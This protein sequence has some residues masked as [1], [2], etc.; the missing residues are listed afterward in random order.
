MKRRTM[1][2]GLAGVAALGSAGAAIKRISGARAG[3]SGLSVTVRLDEPIGTIRPAIYS[4]FAEHIGG[5]IYDGIWV[6]AD[7]KVPNIGGI[8]KALVEHVKR[9]GKVVVRWPGGCFADRYHWRDGIGPV[10]SRP[11]RFGRWREVTEPNTFGTHEF[12]RFCRLCDVEPYFA[13][14]VGTGSPEEYQQWVEYCNAPAGS[15]T[16]ADE[17]AANGQREPLG[18]RYWGVGNESWGCGGKFT[19]EDYC[20]EYRKFTEWLPEYGVKLYLIAAGPN[21]N[22]LDWTRRFFTKWADGARAPIQGWAPHYYCGTTGHALKFTTDQW[23]EQLFKANQME[24][25][26]GDQWA[27]LGLFD[28][29]HK[30]KLVVDEWGSWHPAGTEVNPAHLFE[31]MGTLRDALVA[32]LTLDTFNRHADKVD[33][34]NIAQL[35]NNLHSLFLADGD[36]FVATPNYHVFE[37]YRPHHGAMSVRIDVHA[38]EV[39]FGPGKW[40][41]RI[42]RIAGSASRTGQRQLTLTLVHTHTTD[43]AEVSILLRGGSAREVRQTVLTHKELNAHNTFEQPETVVPRS[44]PTD[45]RGPELHCVLAPASVTRLDVTLG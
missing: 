7:S 39:A 19:P 13:A 30:I 11:R 23:Y 12:I 25:L 45:L 16:L 10:A 21:S 33:M 42:L 29:E 9:L 5:V 22:D 41:K 35:V 15:T 3:A 37:M 20:R 32:A 44:T 38:P 27:V 4:Q 8:R 1:L 40:P 28:P 31:Q 24:T 43:P 14:N 34:A 6:G 36:R 17:R 2:R 26:I 18:I